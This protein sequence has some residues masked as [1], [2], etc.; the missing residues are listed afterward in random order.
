MRKLTTSFII[1]LL[2]VV[3][4]LPV[5]AAPTNANACFGQASAVFAQTGEMGAHASQQATPRLGLANLADALADAGIIADGSMA[6]LGQFV[7]NELG[8]SIEACMAE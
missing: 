6:S 5:L 4:A 2:F 3:T 8:L 1:V 7:A